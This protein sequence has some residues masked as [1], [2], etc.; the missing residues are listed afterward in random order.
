MTGFVY[1]IWYF[2]GLTTDIPRSGLHRIVIAGQPLCLVRRE[3]GRFSAM[4][5][6]CPH[7]AAPFSSGCLKDGTVEC[8]YHGWRFSTDDGHCAEI[9]SLTQDSPIQPDKIKVRTF[10][11]QVTGQ[12]LWVW[13]SSDPK[14]SGDPSI[15]PPHI[16]LCESKPVIDVTK[17]LN[18]HIDHAAIGLVDPAHGP[19]VHKQWWWRQPSSQHEK[20]KDYEPRDIG[21][22]MKA[23]SPSSN[24]AAYKL[25]GGTPVTEITFLLPGIR[26]E[27]ITVGEK[28][29]LS[30]TV[31]TPSQGD[32]SRIRQLFL[33]DHRLFRLLSPGLAYGVKTFLKQDQRILNLQ[34]EGLQFDP[35]LMLVEDA[36]T[37]SKWYHQLKKAWARAQET[38]EPFVN[39][40]KART[41]RWRS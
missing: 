25:L 2:A 12:I 40:V 29:V 7:R 24:S 32:Q 28:T 41:L 33:T 5:D 13:I 22:V 20:S 1:D 34:A 31:V 38:G 26:L 36:D 19:Y 17:P 18:C 23:H 14:F 3:D 21:F 16:P 35:K 4:L 6:I 11:L 27:H 37:L 15:A 30:L 39:P 9:P 8:P 10:P